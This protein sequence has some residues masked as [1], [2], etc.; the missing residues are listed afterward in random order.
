[1]RTNTPLV[2]S[3][4]QVRG[5]ILN[6]MIPIERNGEILGYI[7]A[8]ELTEDIRRQAWKM[9]VRIIIVLT[10]GLLISLLLIVLFSRRLSANIDI[11]TDGLSTLAQ[12]IPTRLPQLPGE[13]GQISQSVNNL[14]QALR[15][16][17]T[18]NDLIIENAAD[19]VIA[20]DRQGDV[21]TMN[22]AA[23]VITG[24]Q[25]H[26]LWGSLTP[27]CSTILSSTVQY[28][29]RWNMAPNMWRWRSVFQVVTAPLN[30]V[31]LP[32]VFITRTV[33]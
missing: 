12:N 9:D 31:S 33:K 1:M 6:S 26:E 3:G 23:E 27:C 13:M 22:P 32:V 15:E 28:W 21:T 14:A 11:I 18:L 24:Y 10:A 16:T 20:I 5:D 25:R 29:I 17:R 2:Y 4:R 19:G 7:W 30:S 8:N